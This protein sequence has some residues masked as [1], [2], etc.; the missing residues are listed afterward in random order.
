[1][2]LILNELELSLSH[3]GTRLKVIFGLGHEPTT[4]D[5]NRWYAL[6]TKYTRQGLPPETAGHKAASEIFV[7]YRTHGYMSEAENISYLLAALKNN[8]RK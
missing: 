1:M 4:V 5:I 7:D 3:F 6:V 8:T 2:R